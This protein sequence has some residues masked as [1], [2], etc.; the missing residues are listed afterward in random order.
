[1]RPPKKIIKTRAEKAIMRLLKLLKEEGW[2]H[3]WEIGRSEHGYRKLL[4]GIYHQRDHDHIWKLVFSVDAE[5]RLL[6]QKGWL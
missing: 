6:E 3:H 4:K 1:M 2:G 5:E